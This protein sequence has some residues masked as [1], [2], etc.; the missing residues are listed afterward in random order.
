MAFFKWAW[1]TIKVCTA[2]P[3]TLYL[4]IVRHQSFVMRYCTTLYLKGLQRYRS[5]K[6][7]VWKKAVF[8]QYIWKAPMSDYWKMRGKGRVSTFR[9][10]H[11][12]LKNAFFLSISLIGVVYFLSQLYDSVCDFQIIHVLR[13]SSP[14]C[15][16]QFLTPVFKVT[17]QSAQRMGPTFK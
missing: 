17:S 10:F 5:S 13:I 8:V 11:A 4:L 15:L 1:Q 16:S 3:L 6:F 2:K 14:K 9:V 7:K 12:Y